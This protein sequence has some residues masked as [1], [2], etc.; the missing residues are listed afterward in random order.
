LIQKECDK[1]PNQNQA[2]KNREEDY[3]HMSVPAGARR[4]A[5]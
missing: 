4:A 1:E 2:D 5:F 3:F